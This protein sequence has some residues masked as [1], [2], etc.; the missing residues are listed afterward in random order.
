M[1]ALYAVVV[2]LALG[3]ATGG[4]LEGLTE[5]RFRWAGLAMAGLLVQLLLFLP[6][7]AERVGGV[8]AAIY[9]ASS[10]LVLVAVLANLA[11]PGLKLAAVGAAANLVAITANGGYMPASPGAL[12]AL[13]KEVGSAY[14]N[15]AVVPDP[16]L[17][18]LTDIWAMPAWLP[19]ANVFSIGDLLLA[20]GIGYAIWAAMRRGVA[21][22][23]GNLPP[24]SHATGTDGS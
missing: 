12:A 20:L 8:G 21:G 3:L 9:A 7:V 13:G 2:A 19:F 23:S 5:L 14:S 1:F 17:E 4:R 24:M 22:A 16:V 6:P 11:I 18:G 10:A 15:S